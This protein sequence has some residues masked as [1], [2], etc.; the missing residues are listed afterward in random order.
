MVREE[1]E[2]MCLGLW[3]LRHKGHTN[4]K[5]MEMKEEGESTLLKSAGFPQ[6]TQDIRLMVLCVCVISSVRAIRKLGKTLTLRQDEEK[7]EEA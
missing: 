3:R 7:G 1:E 5:C 4:D 2:Q 6:R